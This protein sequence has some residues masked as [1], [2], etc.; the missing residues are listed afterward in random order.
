MSAGDANVEFSTHFRIYPPKIIKVSRS[1]SQGL[2]LLS[3][4]SVYLLGTWQ[5]QMVSDKRLHFG[6]YSV[7]MWPE[8]S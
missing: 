1:H 4:M 3:V 2:Y 8:N 7:G 5:K 6:F